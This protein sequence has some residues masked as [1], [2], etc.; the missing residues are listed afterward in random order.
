MKRANSS[1][2]PAALGL[3]ALLAVAAVG[4]FV[5]P[6]FFD[7]LVPQVLPGTARFWTLLSGVAEGAVAVTVALPRTRR[8]GALA[9]ALL[10]LAVWPANFKMAFDWRDRPIGQR[11]VAYG[12]LPLQLPLVFWAWKV[13]RSQHTNGAKS[14][15]H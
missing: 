12:R 14:G 9:S 10:F 2:T 15:P 13:Y 5:R 4:H 11:A 3:A 6:K 8:Y 7:P 1:S